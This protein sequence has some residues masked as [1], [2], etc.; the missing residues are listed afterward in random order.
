MW[1]KLDLTVRFPVDFSSASQES[2]S[3]PRDRR[4]PNQSVDTGNMV[5]A[6]GS[7]ACDLHE[8]DRE[9]FQA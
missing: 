7:K 8:V 6:A 3:K 9:T 2:V 1:L 4:N 5:F